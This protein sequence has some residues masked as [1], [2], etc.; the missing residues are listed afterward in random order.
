MNGGVEDLLS[1]PGAPLLRDPGDERI[2]G[3]EECSRSAIIGIPWDWSV[4]G[5]PGPRLAPQRIR[6]YLYGLT[7]YSPVHGSITCR[8]RD[9]GDVRV[10]PG[11]WSTTRARIA[12]VSITLLE[13]YERVYLVGGDHS[14]AGPA[15]EA[16]A[17]VEDRVSLVMLDHHYDLR[18]TSEGLTS[19]SWLY[20]VLT[21][22]P[23]RIEALI[24]GVGDYSNPSYLAE[25][26][27]RL[28]VKVIPRHSLLQGDGLDTVRE[29]LD[30]LEDPVYLS[31]DMDHLDQAYAPGV[32][33]PGVMGMDPRETLLIL[34]GLAGKRIRM[35][36]LVEVNPLVDVADSTSR[37]AAK[38]LAYLFNLLE[39]GGGA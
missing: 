15:L 23:G 18:S 13:E 32:N 36:D 14:I 7:P 34:E 2:G 16:L 35:I 37:L 4:T 5:R 38:V 21:R 33:S 27:M 19:G 12:S 17:H 24:V 8:P 26:A 10:A 3:L 1:V 25:R 29:A 11:L 28:G 31:I 39:A 9:L 22:V 6:G 20:E 30:S